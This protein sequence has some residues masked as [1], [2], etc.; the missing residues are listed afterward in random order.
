MWAM[1]ALCVTSA[2]SA[3]AADEEAK[4]PDFY[5]GLGYEWDLEN[6]ES[7]LSLSFAGSGK[8]RTGPAFG[9]YDDKL[10]LGVSYMLLG[11]RADLDSEIYGGPTLLWYDDHIGGGLLVGRH[12][13]REV[14]VEAS[15]R[16]TSD[17]D[18]EAELSVGYG[19]EW[20]W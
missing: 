19:F 17:W 13:T 4:P 8:G 12:L 14:I 20:P 6:E 1:I 3:M 10:L 2:L 11:P 18:G 16:A 15:Y 5:V 9:L 7:G